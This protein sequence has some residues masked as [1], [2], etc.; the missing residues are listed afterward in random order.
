MSDTKQVQINLRVPN[1]VAT[2]LDTLAEQEH[3]SRV[4]VARQILLDGLTQRKHALALR[5]YQEDK[6]S[7]SRAAEIAGISLWEMIDLIEEASLPSTYTLEEATE[8]M[9]RLVAQLSTI[10]PDSDGNP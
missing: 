2:D 4:D 9:R 5:L 1:E 3:L 7:K 8:D 6:Y 10:P